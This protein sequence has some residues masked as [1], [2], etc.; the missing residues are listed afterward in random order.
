MPHLQT[1]SN[2][3]FQL[4]P[5]SVLMNKCI[6]PQD[7]VAANGFT[8]NSNDFCPMEAYSDKIANLSGDDAIGE[9]IKYLMFAVLFL[10][11]IISFIRGMVSLVKLGEGGQGQGVGRSLTFIFAG[12]VAINADSFYQLMENI[13]VR[14][15][16]IVKRI[17]FKS[18]C[19]LKWIS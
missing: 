11:G 16:Y 15:T 12:I 19:R 9:A 2:S 1:I 10:V 5:Q 14:I 13:L 17:L 6:N 3:L 8:T 4:D 18:A 7:V